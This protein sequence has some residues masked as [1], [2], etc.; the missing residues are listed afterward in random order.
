MLQDEIRDSKE[1]LAQ[2]WAAAVIW[3]IKE[4]T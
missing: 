4:S 3:E 1:A 2:T